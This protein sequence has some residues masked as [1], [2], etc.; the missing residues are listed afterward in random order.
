MEMDYEP[1]ST[2]PRT[3]DAGYRYLLI[4]TKKKDVL[5]HWLYVISYEY[6]VFLLIR[7]TEFLHQLATMVTP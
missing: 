6:I 7:K 1:S 4:I 5:N 2:T 3:K